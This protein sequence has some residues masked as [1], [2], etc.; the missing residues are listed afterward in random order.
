MAN[1]DITLVLPGAYTLTDEQREAL[2]SAIS[3]QLANVQ[4]AALQDD[5]PPLPEI[6]DP[7][8]A[9]KRRVA[10]KPTVEARKKKR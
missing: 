7:T 9:A 8:R 10:K 2:K 5:P 4:L 6:N 3:V 1:N